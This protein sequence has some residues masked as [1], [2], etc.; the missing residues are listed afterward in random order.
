MWQHFSRHTVNRFK[1]QF[2]VNGRLAI[3][4]MKP[5][6]VIEHYD[7]YEHGLLPRLGFDRPDGVSARF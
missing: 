5:L 6:A 4:G 1:L 2:V 7:K 3:G